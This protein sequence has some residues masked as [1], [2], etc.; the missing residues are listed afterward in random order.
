MK[1][2]DLRDSY[3]V[4][5]EV[6]P[7]EQLE[8]KRDEQGHMS[9]V[10][11]AD[12]ECYGSGRFWNSACARFGFGK[13]I[14]KLF[15]EEEVFDR[16]A[17]QV[18]NNKISGTGHI[19]VG[20]QTDAKG[21]KTALAVSNPTKGYLSFDEA[22]DVVEASG[23][24]DVSYF[25]GTISS[26]HTPRVENKFE[27][28]GDGFETRFNMDAPI[29]GYG[30]PSIYLGLL[31]EVCSNGMIGMAKAF[32][33]NLAV[34]KGEDS[35]T[36]VMERALDGFND[37]EGYASLRQR[38]ESSGKSW[39]SIGEAMKLYDLLTEVSA[40]KH[41]QCNLS[42]LTGTDLARLHAKGTTIDMVLADEV[43][44]ARIGYR[45]VIEAFHEM[46]GDI[47]R[48]YGIANMDAFSA[49][50]QRILP[51]DATVYQLVNFATE[52]RTHILND[53]DVYLQ[54]K[55]DA[56]VGNLF[57]DEYDLEGTV[58][59]YPNFEDFMIDTK[60][61]NGLTGSQNTLAV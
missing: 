3:D 19:R 5:Y 4:D 2:K 20:I 29:D 49:K 47:I 17:Y 25:D 45:P 33:T 51:V 22:L 48:T 10:I 37:D 34:G 6:V 60:F 59:R 53:N 32:R 27:V 23:C 13:N 8:F 14:F 38:V 9:K 21:H 24:T 16:I 43:D 39:A 61:S 7:V 52:V 55:F 11:I 28:L 46:T 57:C 30:L 44:E 36:F 35:V 50:K 40:L 56:Y 26:N 31:R 54:R 15:S 12:H 18:Q 1:V 58:D 41:A 42:N